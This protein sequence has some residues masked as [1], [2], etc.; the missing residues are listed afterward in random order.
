MSGNNDEP[1][2]SAASQITSG[3]PVDWNKVQNQVT[4]PDEAAVAAE[5]RSLERFAQVNETTPATWGRFQIISE[6]GR[7][8]F[9]TVYCAV[10]PTLRLEVALKVIRSR[11]P[12]IPIDQEKALD[13]ARR[14]VKVKHPNVVRAYGAELIDN[15]V[16]LS[17][18][19]VKGQTLDEIVRRQATFSANEAAVIGIDLCRALAA[20]HRADILHGDIKAHNVMREQGGRTVLMD[21]GTGRQLNREPARSGNDFAGTPLYIAPEVFAGRPRTPASEIYSLGVLLYFLVTGSYP[22][23]GDSRTIIERLHDR[24]ARR[25]SLRDVRPDLPDSFIRVVEQ[26]TAENPDQRYRTAGELEAALVRVLSPERRQEL[27]PASKFRPNWRKLALVAASIVVVATAW[28][29][30]QRM[31]TQATPGEAATVAVS[32][33][34]AVTNTPTPGTTSPASYRIESAFYR[35]SS[36]RVERLRP[37]AKLTPGDALSLQV[38]TSIPMYLYVVNEDERGESYLL[39]PLPGHALQ[40]PLPPGQR[41]RLPNMQ[42]GELMSWRVTSAGRREHFLIVASPERSTSF[43]ELFATLPQ[44]TRGHPPQNAKLSTEA[45]GVLR[46]VGGLVPSPAK[47]DRQLRLMPEFSTALSEGEESAS[48]VWIRHATFMNPEK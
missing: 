24:S 22:V 20:V 5:L 2:L 9:G 45:I 30:A 28:F 23:E 36:G 42:D 38:Q 8:T 32:P 44:P 41:H 31:L 14:L 3:V 26:A 19:F 35:E 12:G 46:S 18:E 7:G 39:F 33:Q 13:E 25:Q 17:M 1:L 27:D 4:T 47:V 48:G 10:D 21:F 11:I 43:D 16:G 34:A 29:T 15:E 40:N 6:I 37:G